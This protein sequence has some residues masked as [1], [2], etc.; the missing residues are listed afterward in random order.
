M[1][2][3]VTID[4]FAKLVAKSPVAVRSAMVRGLHKAAMRMEVQVVEEIDSTLPHPPVDVGTMRQS[5]SLSR[6]ADGADVF[7][8]APHAIFMEEGTRPHRPPMLPLLEWA[9]RKG[10]DNPIAV[11]RAVVKRIELEGIAP[12]FYFK[13]AYHKTLPYVGTAINREMKALI[14]SGKL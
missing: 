2:R 6:D 14:K 1:A 8:T 12:R 9:I 10:F 11:A 4:Q 5:T 7:M 3:R 13:R